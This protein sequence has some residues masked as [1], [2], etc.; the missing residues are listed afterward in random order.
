[1]R[2]DGDE[3]ATDADH[4]DA[5]HFSRT[6]MT[7]EVRTC[8]RRSDTFDMMRLR[9]RWKGVGALRPPA[10]QVSGLR[11]G[12]AEMINFAADGGARLER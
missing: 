1:V 9:S 2:L 10:T 3:M 6:Y 5:G 11:A 12:A 7:S 4:G 8:G